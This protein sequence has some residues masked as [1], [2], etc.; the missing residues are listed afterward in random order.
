MLN[1][2]LTNRSV[3]CIMRDCQECRRIG[4]VCSCH[5]ICRRAIALLSVNPSHQEY[6]RAQAVLAMLP[7]ARLCAAW[8]RMPS[9][10]L[11]RW[12]RSTMLMWATHEAYQRFWQGI[13]YA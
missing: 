9:D 7:L 2:M 12:V 5:D 8:N 3:A 10:D 11:A 13:Q 1:S 6:R 4:C